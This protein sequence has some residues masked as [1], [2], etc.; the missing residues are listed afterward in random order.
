VY[1]KHKKI[2]GIY[3]GL[4]F[5]ETICILAFIVEIH[6]ATGGNTLSWAYVVEWP[7][8]ALYIVYM[9]Q[10]LLREEKSAPPNSDGLVETPEEPDSPALIA[11]NNY[12]RAVH[13]LPE[14]DEPSPSSAEPRDSALPPAAVP[15]DAKIAESRDKLPVSRRQGP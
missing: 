5:G 14:S 12:F 9:W 2:L 6:R 8:F 4:I 7:I 15:P 1:E 13:G 3:T 11:L 10:R